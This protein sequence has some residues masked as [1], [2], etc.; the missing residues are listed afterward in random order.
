MHNIRDLHLDGIN[1]ED[2]VDRI[3]FHGCHTV[4]NSYNSESDAVSVKEKV[5]LK[6]GRL[7]DNIRLLV[8]YERPF[9]ITNPPFRNHKQ[10]KERE[11]VNHLTEFKSTDRL[12][13]ENIK[14]ALGNFYLGNTMRDVCNN[15]YIYGTDIPIE[16]LVK[17]DYEKDRKTSEQHPYSYGTF[18]IET[19]TADY[20]F[21][22]Q[23]IMG[24]TVTGKVIQTTVHNHFIRQFGDKAEKLIRNKVDELIGHHVK[25]LGL[26]LELEFVNDPGA[27]AK[28]SIERIHETDVDIIGI[29]NMDFDIPRVVETLVNYGYDPAE[30]FSDPKIPKE[31]KKFDYNKGPTIKKTEAG[32]ET[33]IPF[34]ER[35]NTASFPAKWTVLDAMCVYF[36]LRRVGGNESGGYGLDA[37]LQRNIDMGKLK[38]EEADGYVRKAW[39]DFMQTNYPIEYIVYNIFDS[40]GMYI[41]EEKNKDIQVNFP[42]LCGVTPFKTAS[43]NP[44]KFCDD[45]HFDLLESKSDEGPSVLGSTGRQMV[46][47][48]DDNVVD[49]KG[50]VL[51][52][53]AN[54]ME[55]NG[56]N[57]IK[58]MEGL[59]PSFFIHVS[60][61]DIEGTYPNEQ[62]AFNI[63]KETTRYEVISIEGVDW[64]NRRRFGVQLNAGETNAGNLCPNLFKLPNYT[65]LLD[66]FLE[67][68]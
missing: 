44:K 22:D 5:L 55:R 27:V 66:K 40:L 34:H 21:M 4:S 6:D 29:W 20:E 42:L 36:R 26:N 17:K 59:K 56:V 54:M 31:F 41:L 50:W 37:V 58:D 53:Q 30:V 61:L 25:K 24:T 15:P 12:L 33:P 35:W 28:R 38:F 62:V 10:K 51:T 13:V 16:S 32:K 45:L 67:S 7:I 9:W 18:D 57:F 39:H 52:L 46:V 47:E 8:D 23:P 49:R 2:I 3:Y 14:R 63:S 11:L 48:E 60:D 1:K 64:E 65:E 43:S 19:Y 68:N